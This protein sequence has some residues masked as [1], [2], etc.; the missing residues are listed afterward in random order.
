MW[1][2]RFNCISYVYKHVYT[3]LAA[4][5]Y[6]F[7]HAGLEQRPRRARKRSFGDKEL[8]EKL[9]PII[10]AG[11]PPPR[12]SP[13]NGAGPEIDEQ[14]AVGMKVQ[15]VTTGSKREKLLSPPEQSH[16]DGVV[17][18]SESLVWRG[19]SINI[20]GKVLYKCWES[21]LFSMLRKYIIHHETFYL[22]VVQNSSFMGWH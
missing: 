8:L 13:S 22:T 18:L 19:F 16:V 11:M 14:D 12:V 17:S 2:T 21:T 10:N 1:I 5:F 4:R 15:S 6:C 3:Y 9:A 20:F 7:Q